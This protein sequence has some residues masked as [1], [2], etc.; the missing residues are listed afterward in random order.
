MYEHKEIKMGLKGFTLVEVL[1]TLSIL[2]VVAA[3]NIPSI[4]QNYK[5][6]VTIVRVKKAYS[7]LSQAYD[8]AVVEHGPIEN[9]E[10][11]HTI[12]NDSTDEEKQANKDAADIILNKLTPYL[13]TP[14]K[15][16]IGSNDNYGAPFARHMYEPF[17]GGTTCIDPAA[18]RYAKFQLADGMAFAIA[19]NG[20]EN[21]I[22]PAKGQCAQI[23][24]DINGDKA[25]N[26]T[27][28][29]LFQFTI[30]HNRE[31]GNSYIEPWFHSKQ[32]V[33]KGNGCQNG[34]SCAYW[35]I[36]KGNMDYLK[37]D[38]SAEY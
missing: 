26:I 6:R 12:N 18:N 34:A 21:C 32:C 31:T 24:V 1:V 37:R 10:I 7:M 36:K 4:I 3:I 16:Y 35:I 19:S 22:L 20:L 14:I 25:P 23:L 9:W 33:Y 11:G 29:D 8:L 5:E 15:R 13:R 28:R 38:I 17:S 27:G 30:Y 2:G